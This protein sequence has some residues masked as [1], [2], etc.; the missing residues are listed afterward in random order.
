M[1]AVAPRKLA[2]ALRILA[3]LSGPPAW[4]LGFN[5]G[6]L[7]AV[8]LTLQREPLLAVSKQQILAAEGQVLFARSAFDTFKAGV[9]Q[10]QPSGLV[11]N[12]AVTLTRIR[13]NYTNTTGPA[14]SNVA[15]NFEDAF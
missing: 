2:P 12:P 7:D 10:R 11:I 8:L 15:L 9:S 3:G 4:A 1:D 5:G 14:S 6:L 13:D